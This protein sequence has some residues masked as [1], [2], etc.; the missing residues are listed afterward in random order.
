MGSQ[1]T[2]RG[3]SSITAVASCPRSSCWCGTWSRPATSRSACV[4]AAIDVCFTLFTGLVPGADYQ[5]NATLV[6]EALRKL[7]TMDKEREAAE[8]AADPDVY[9]INSDT[10]NDGAE[11]EV[12]ALGTWSRP[13]NA[14][15]AKALC[16]THIAHDQS[17]RNGADVL[18]RQLDLAGRKPELC[19]GAGGDSTDHAIKQ[20][21]GLCSRL[22]AKGL[23]AGRML[24]YGCVRH[25]KELELKAAFEAGWPGNVSENFLFSLRYIIHKDVP[26]WRGVWTNSGA[27]TAPVTV[28]NSSLASMPNPTASK[29]ECMDVACDKF[30]RTY[31]V[32]E[33]RKG[34]GITM[35]EEFV[36]RA[37]HLLRGTTD[38]SMPQKAG[39]H[40]DKEKFNVLAADLQNM[41]LMG[42]IYATLDLARENSGPFHDW[43][44]QK[45]PLYGWGNDF[46]AHLMAVKA[47]EE[48]DFWERAQADPTVAFPL[49]HAFMKRSFNRQYAELMNADAQRKL[50][51]SMKAAINAGK[52]KNAEWMLK[53]Y[54]AAP[55]LYGVVTDERHRLLAAQLILCAFGHEGQLKAKM[56]A[57]QLSMAQPA[58]TV[59]LRLQ[60]CFQREAASGQ[61]R[62]WWDRWGLG[63][64]LDEW[65]LLATTP[66]QNYHNPVFRAERTPVMWARLRP[67]FVLMVHNTR[68]ESYV[69][70]QKQLQQ[71]HNT[72]PTNVNFIFM[73]HASME[74]MRSTL[75]AWE[76]RSTDVRYGAGRAVVRAKAGTRKGLTDTQRSKRQR[77][78]LLGHIGKHELPHYSAGQLYS[79]LSKSHTSVASTLRAAESADKAVAVAVPERKLAALQQTHTS[80]P[81]RARQPVKPPAAHAHK[82]P[83]LAEAGAKVAK[84]RGTGRSAADIAVRSKAAKRA[85]G[86]EQPSQAG[87]AA[88]PTATQKRKQRESDAQAL[89]K[90]RAIPVEQRRAEAEARE[91]ET[92]TA[93]QRVR[94]EVAQEER[95]RAAARSEQEEEQ[96]QLRAEL[97][98]W[99]AQNQRKLKPSDLRS[100]P[101]LKVKY[102]R[103][104]DLCDSLRGTHT[105]V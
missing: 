95:E 50:T 32:S 100:D 74:P 11:R 30:L 27:G 76:A 61:L 35:I 98:A 45:C 16:C 21:T 64:S 85:K 56:A 15:V 73:H 86:A 87:K 53:Q 66:S 2:P 36:D 23:E 47:C 52:D 93:A 33:A 105:N 41:Q 38:E 84:Q 102:S 82:A 80:G 70:K 63:A 51:A 72:T 96:K 43:C 9:S 29:W 75:S 83:Q 20:R 28:Y 101:E 14:P 18:D 55:F 104:R 90:R 22:E 49:L 59:Q 48:A 44:K 54:T 58:G 78:M 81:C 17:G 1:F 94:E 26:F 88:V 3:R 4:C 6:V 57:A 71:G 97:N 69:S 40:G 62:A 103:Y 99:E 46:K 77:Q 60:A 19:V 24:I 91:A 25:F 10:G 34:I 67:L 5:I 79:R 68:L 12:A 8:A 13:L 65:L 7:G 39:T 37:R 89:A 31:E 92:R 42:A